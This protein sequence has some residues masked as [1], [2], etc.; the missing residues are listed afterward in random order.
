MNTTED[1]T[2]PPMPPR[3]IEDWT[4]QPAGPSAIDG[5]AAGP[6][7][8]CDAIDVHGATDKPG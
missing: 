1:A 6:F 2:N 4:A 8:I 7:A 5:W 3:L